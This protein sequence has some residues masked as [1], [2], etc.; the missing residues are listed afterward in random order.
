MIKFS[1]LRQALS[2]PRVQRAWNFEFR[3]WY[4]TTDGGLSWYADYAPAFNDYVNEQ[5]A[6]GSP[7]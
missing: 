7:K 2:A 5:L 1:E 6:E 4:Y 3:R